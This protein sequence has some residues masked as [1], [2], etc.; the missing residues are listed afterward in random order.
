MLGVSQTE[1]HLIL[2]TTCMVFLLLFSL[3][4]ETEAQRAKQAPDPSDGKCQGL[5]SNPSSRTLEPPL[6]AMALLLEVRILPQRQKPG[7]ATTNR[8]P[9]SIPFLV[10]LWKPEGRNGSSFPIPSNSDTILQLQ[11]KENSKDFSSCQLNKSQCLDP[12]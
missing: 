7:V 10:L 2:A 5:D 3:G 12:K 6:L 11:E 4:K 8:R 9:S 1:S